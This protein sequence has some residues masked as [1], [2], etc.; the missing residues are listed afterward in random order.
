MLAEDE[1]LVDAHDVLLVISI[2]FFQL[3]QNA[4]LDESLF[5]KTFL[6]P[7]NLECDRLFIFMIVALENLP[8]RPLADLLLDLEPVRDVVVD[9]ADVLIFVIVKP[10]IF[11]AGGGLHWLLIAL[12]D[13]QVP[14]LVV[15]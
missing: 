8:K 5:E 3:L 10:V 11:G 2:V 14:H 4:S 1:L 6:I 12:A 9:L 15:L 7:K 13:G